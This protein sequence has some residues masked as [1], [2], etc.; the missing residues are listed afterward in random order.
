MNVLH[1]C[2]RR[3]L[4]WVDAWYY[5]RYRLRTLG[6][7]LF[8]G[9]ATYRG[10]RIDFPDGTVLRDNDPICRLHF[11]NANIAALGEGSMQRV[12]F[13]FAKLMR[14]SL[15]LL[16]TAARTDPQLQGISVFQGVTWIPSHGEVVGFVSTPMPEGWRTKLL[17]AHFR[18]LSWVFAPASRIRD[19][20]N[21][22]PRLY[23]LT[24]TALTSNVSK[25]KVDARNAGSSDARTNSLSLSAKAS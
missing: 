7:V 2:A 9:S 13:R 25:L 12:G 20:G 11:N 21:T 4:G 1:R 10:P 5:R 15:R 3:V 23:W 16:E 18:M 22:A 24:R 8:I 6:P 19:R 14:E 17:T